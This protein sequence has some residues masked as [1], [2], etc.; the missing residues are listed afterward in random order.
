MTQ[1]LTGRAAV[2]AVLAKLKSAGFYD[3]EIDGAYGP[4]ADAGL[5]RAL[6]QALAGVETMKPPALYGGSDPAMAWGR[7]LTAAERASVRWIVS[8][9]GGFTA[10]DLMDCIA[11][12]SGGTFSPS[13]VNKAGSGATGLIQFMPS[14]AKSLGTT[15]ADL[16]R[17][18]VVQQL[19][20]VY[21]YFRP[22]KGRLKGLGDLYMAILW[23]AAV[24]KPDT[25]V[26][27]DKN[28]RPTTYRQNAGLD[29]D[30]DGEITRGEALVRVRAYA[31]A[32][33]HPSNYWAGA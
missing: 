8:D 11:W 25:F 28:S 18:T 29:V 23:P 14:T 13:I 19:N 16:S 3:G 24:G 6:A 30:R 20:Y 33:R 7:K 1:I 5:T 22:F 21:K 17:M 32:G 26:L 9:L 27:W 10:D 12:E 15:T 31:A 4:L 2:D